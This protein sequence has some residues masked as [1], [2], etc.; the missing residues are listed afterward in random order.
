L[1]PLLTVATVPPEARLGGA[2]PGPAVDVADRC[3]DAPDVAPQLAVTA[4]MSA[5]TNGGPAR[6]IFGQ[7]TSHASY[8]SASVVPAAA[9][10]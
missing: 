7:G 8:D 3:G 9:L 2:A 5:T 10:P 1:L 4:A 6:F